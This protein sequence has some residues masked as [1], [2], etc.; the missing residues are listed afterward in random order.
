MRCDALY[1]AWMSRSKSIST[2]LV[3]TAC[4]YDQSAFCG[5][6]SSRLEILG[7]PFEYEFCQFL[8]IVPAYWREI[9]IGLV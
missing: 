4:T 1:V 3:N 6:Y 7:S 2:D 9:R 5:V 8:G